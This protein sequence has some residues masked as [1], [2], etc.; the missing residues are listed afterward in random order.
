MFEEQQATLEHHVMLAIAIPPLPCGRLAAG[1]AL[2][3]A[4]VPN[5]AGARKLRFR[6]VAENDFRTLTSHIT[7]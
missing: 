4:K 1:D 3:M 5:D 6:N 2:A 7:V